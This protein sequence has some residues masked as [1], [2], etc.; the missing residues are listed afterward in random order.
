M[1][2]EF[3]EQILQTG[4]RRFL[5]ACQCRPVDRPPV[6]L[7]RQA[8]RC[9]PEYRA[10]KERYSF[11]QMVQT[12]ELA[13]EVT[14]QPIRRFGMDA[15]IIF[16]DIL[17]ISEALGQPYHFRE[18]GGI[19]MAYA[20]QSAADI[21]KLDVSRVA[22]HLQYTTE[23]LQLVSNA[24]GGRAAL[25]GFVGSP[26]TLANFMIEGGSSR[27]WTKARA[28]F[29]ENRGLYNLLCE[30]LTRA[31]TIYA[32]NQID[33]GVDALQIFDSLGGL[34]PG[35][36]F[37]AAS[38]CWIQTI[39]AALEDRVPVIVF[40]KGMHGNWNALL[41][42][43]AQ[44]IGVDWTIP[45][46]QVSTYLP[47][48]LALQGNLDPVLLT[49]SPAAVAAATRSL[50][51]EMRGRPGHVLNLGHGVPPKAKLECIEALLTTVR[52]DS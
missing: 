15:A 44:V 22:D 18:G 6:W 32:Q 28:L 52:G 2:I 4:A 8:G 31:I 39:I 27:D 40:S 9:L 25:L 16:S 50:L 48:D 12:P 45:L 29:Y 26:W 21:E 41:Q 35:D 20:L 34:L 49:T 47:P 1:V 38:G 42:T 51:A 13:A 43:G 3:K 5:D 37:E 36:Q 23:A 30:K 11:L 19:Q 46:S 17:V 33:A 10:L 24:L 7:M 14:L